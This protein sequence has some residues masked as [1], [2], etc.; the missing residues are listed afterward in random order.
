MRDWA[1]KEVALQQS[2]RPWVDRKA[3][4]LE[5]VQRDLLCDIQDGNAHRGCARGPGG[6]E[7]AQDVAF[8]IFGEFQ[9]RQLDALIT[10]RHAGQWGFTRS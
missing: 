2:V 1:F 7:E 8:A 6:F 10:E 5:G 4:D 3:L 9:R